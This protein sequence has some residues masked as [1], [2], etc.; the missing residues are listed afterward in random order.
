MSTEAKRG[1]SL[2][3][4]TAVV[5]A[6]MIGTGVFTSLGFQ[7]GDLPSGFTILMLWLVGGVCAFCGAMC[8][9]ELAAAL[10]RSGGEYHFLSRI[11]HPAVG[12][13]SGW[14]SVTVGFA[15]P[16]ALAAMAFGEYFSTIFPHAPAT[17]WSLV[18]VWLITLVHVGG[19]KMAARFQN[20]ATWLKVALICVFIASAWIMTQGVPVRFTPLASD[21][22]LITSKPFAVS[23]VYVMY[24]YAGWNAAAYIVGDIREPQKNV[25]KAIALGT[26]MVTVLYLALNAS[27]LHAAPMGALAGKLD[28]GHVAA[29]HIFGATGGKIMSGLICLGLASSISA[30]TWLGPR[31]LHT[32]GEDMSILKP[33]AAC[34]QNG[35]PVTGLFVQL[36][37][38][39]TLLLTASFKTVLTAVQFSIQLASFATVVG[40]F[41]LRW[42]QP[43]LPR[44]YRCWGYPITPLL[45]LAISA[46][47]MA[48]LMLDK[49]SRDASLYGLGLIA[50]GLII[51][52]IS[53]RTERTA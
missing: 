7:V 12:F 9:G 37:I 41:V 53:P 40:L 8:Y 16:I 22:G 49:E 3:T 39:I 50:L 45:F 35:V 4:A 17:T 46:W 10:P 47:M 18:M 29:E 44:P 19:V 20:L 13:L 33:L 23:L 48:F 21:T 51:F 28:V 32:M 5:V 30:M 2:V 27:F 25:P 14:L 1:I 31:V 11:F 15:A 24:S 38:V 42:K 43:D 52:F 6:N 34:D 26:L 36:S